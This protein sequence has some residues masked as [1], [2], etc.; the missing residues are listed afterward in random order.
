MD[1]FKIISIIFMMIM[2]YQIYV[3]NKAVFKD[4]VEGFEGATQSLGGVDDA[5]SIN[6]LAQIARKLMNEGLTVPGNMTV[7]GVLSPAH[8]VWHTSTDGK[9]RLHYGNNSHTYYK[10]ADAHVWRNRDDTDRMVLDHAANLRVDGALTVQGHINASVNKWN[11]SSDGK[12]RI[13][14]TNNAETVYGSSNGVHVFRSGANGGGPDG[15]TLNQNSVLNVGGSIVAQGRNILAELDGL[16]RD[17]NNC[18]K[19]GEQII[20]QSR[21]NNQCSMLSAYGVR[22]CGEGSTI[23]FIRKI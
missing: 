14:F 20:I 12:N 3:L 9:H 2:I 7:N 1:T 11:T 19:N 18:V 5:N 10:T 6:T 21:E 13:H 4:K 16:R 22:N 17:V 8:S 15:M 23:G